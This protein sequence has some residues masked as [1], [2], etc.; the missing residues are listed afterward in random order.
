MTRATYSSIRIATV[1]LLL[2]ALTVVDDLAA[3]QPTNYPLRCNLRTNGL[4]ITPQGFMLQFR[5]TAAGYNEEAPPKGYCAWAGRGWREGE[6][7][8]AIWNSGENLGNVVVLDRDNQAIRLGYNSD[9]NSTTIET[10]ER[11]FQAWIGDGSVVLHV[12][13]QG[14][15]LTVVRVGSTS[16][17]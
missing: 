11:F 13:R 17:N 12:Y 5:G 7:Q 2:G 8:R 10:M 3:Q 6:P 14:N 9:V 4:R 1:A 16:R 15:A